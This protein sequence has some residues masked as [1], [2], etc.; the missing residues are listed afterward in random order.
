[1]RSSA[2]RTSQTVPKNRRH[3]LN[4]RARGYTATIIFIRRCSP[5][6][7]MARAVRTPVEPLSDLRRV[8]STP[9]PPVAILT[10]PWAAAMR[11]AGYPLIAFSG[12]RLD[13]LIR[14]LPPGCTEIYTHPAM[15]AD[16]EMCREQAE[17]ARSVRPVAVAG[18]DSDP[19]RSL[20]AAV[21][22][23]SWRAAS[24]IQ[25]AGRSAPQYSRIKATDKD[26]IDGGAKTV[27]G[28]IKETAGKIVGDQK[29]I[30]EGQAEKPR[31]SCRARSAG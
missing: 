18:V 16:G 20:D 29:T 9:L 24:I 27:A 11:P 26:R 22:S 28:T 15:S 7:T 17:A 10:A 6:P 13:G 1:M 21:G 31:E 23:R 5:A 14:S 30:A 2:P 8:E 12:Q 3:P 25:I 4:L 19:V